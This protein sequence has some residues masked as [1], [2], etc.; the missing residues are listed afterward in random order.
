MEVEE[1]GPMLIPCEWPCAPPPLEMVAT[2][3]CESLCESRCFFTSD[4]LLIDS[5]GVSRPLDLKLRER[6]AY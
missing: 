4:A 6:V 5:L 1:S 3:G 2:F